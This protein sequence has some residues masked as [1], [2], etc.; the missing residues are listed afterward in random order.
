VPSGK[1]STS[2][3]AS[4][5]ASAG[6]RLTWPRP[7]SVSH[8]NAASTKSSCQRSAELNLFDVGNPLRQLDQTGITARW[9]EQRQAQRRTQAL[10]Q[11][12]RYLRE[13]RQASNA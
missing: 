13:T 11:R 6:K 4:F 1:P 10:A 2:R 7:V 12:H 5:A 8:S 9:P 3:W